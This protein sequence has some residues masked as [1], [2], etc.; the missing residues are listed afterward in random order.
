MHCTP[1]PTRWW[2]PIQA[3]SEGATE[4]VVGRKTA[5]PDI[6]NGRL[7]SP[8]QQAAWGMEQR[9]DGSNIREARYVAGKRKW[10][11]AR[12]TDW[13]SSGMCEGGWKQWCAN[14]AEEQEMHHGVGIVKM[15]NDG[16]VIIKKKYWRQMS[17]VR[18]NSKL[19]FFKKKKSEL[20]LLGLYKMLCVNTYMCRRSMF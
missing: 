16:R 8:T 12:S 15:E 7:P 11:V 1:S 19:F 4:Q 17:S 5:S 2:F 3:G 10:K 20:Y 18:L 14:R 13:Q 9:K 6:L